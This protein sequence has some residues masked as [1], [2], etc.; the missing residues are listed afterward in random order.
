[1]KDWLVNG[2]PK[3]FWMPGFFFPQ[4]FMTG[5]LQN[6]ARRYQIPIDTLS[7]RFEVQ[8]ETH[9]SQVEK[10]P[11]DGIYI[12]GLFLDGARWN[13]Q[14]HS[15]QESALGELYSVSSIISVRLV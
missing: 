1:M 7:F 10:P 5:A 13:A 4:G 6:H 15:V 3:C 8:R 2:Q 12:S 14:T 9:A 11:R